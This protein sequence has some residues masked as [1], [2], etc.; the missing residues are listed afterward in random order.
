MI[1]IAVLVDENGRTS[2]LKEGGKIVVYTKEGD[3][4]FWKTSQEIT[5]SISPFRSIVEIRDYIVKVISSIK[6]CNIFV[7]KEVTGQLF[8]TLELKDF[9]VYE[10]D[11][12]PEEFLDSIRITELNELNPE[13]EEILEKPGLCLKPQE[14]QEKG[15]FFFNLKDAL[16]SDPE[17]TSKKALLPFVNEKK[18]KKLEII[19]DHIPNWFERE[20]EKQ[21]IKWSSEKEEDGNIRVILSL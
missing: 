15:T 11:G 19:C 12:K 6:K 5:F 10:I 1:S 2:T 18:F 8:A 14:T 7:G 16:L 17:L 20:F 4:G 3:I 9:N 21:G 13:K